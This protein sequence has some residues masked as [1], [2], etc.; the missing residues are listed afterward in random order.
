MLCALEGQKISIKQRQTS[1]GLE[2]G[3]SYSWACWEGWEVKKKKEMTMKPSMGNDDRGGL[4]NHGG[5]CATE[6]GTW[7]RRK[8]AA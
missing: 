2:T 1:N 6:W 5:W 4:E 7:T 3:E 8:T